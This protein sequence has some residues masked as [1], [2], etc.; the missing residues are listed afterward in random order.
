MI[1]AMEPQSRVSLVASANNGLG[2][3]GL[4]YGC[5]VL[6]VKVLDDHGLGSYADLAEAIVYAVD[7]ERSDQH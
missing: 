7:H 5:A 2:M 1:T 4:C 6:P 3:A